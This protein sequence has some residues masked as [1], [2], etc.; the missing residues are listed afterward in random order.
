MTARDITLRLIGFIYLYAV[1]NGPVQ[2][3]GASMGQVT[4]VLA[5]NGGYFF[6]STGVRSAAPACASAVNR[7]VIN[8]GTPQGQAIAATLLTAQSMR[9]RVIVNGTGNCAVWPDTET[10]EYI[11]LEDQ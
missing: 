11:L 6:N 7:W 5:H 9:K 4:G 1:S 3:G 10:V 2:A 8:T